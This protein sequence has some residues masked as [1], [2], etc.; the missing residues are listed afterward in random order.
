VVAYLTNP[1]VLTDLVASE[2]EVSCIFTHPLE[3]LLDPLIAKGEQLVMMGSEDWPYTTI[4]HVWEKVFF[5]V[6][7]PLTHM[8]EH[9]RF[10]LY[11]RGSLSHA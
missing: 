1:S 7:L 11:T 8:L 3:A 6:F 10:P 4:L 9:D 5:C 2:N